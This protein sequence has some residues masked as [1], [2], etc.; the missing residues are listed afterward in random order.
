MG[1]ESVCEMLTAV[2]AR[3]AKQSILRHSGMVR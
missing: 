3:V 1:P 2:I